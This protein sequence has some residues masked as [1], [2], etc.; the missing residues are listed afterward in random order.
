MKAT[1]ILALLVAATYGVTLDTQQSTCT[2]C[3]FVI[4]Q[5]ESLIQQNATEQEVLGFIEDA[6]NVLPSPY[7]SL[8][9]AEIQA[10]GPQIIQYIINQEPPQTVCTQL[11]LCQSEIREEHKEKVENLNTQSQ[12]TTTTE[13]SNSNCE[14]CNYIVGVVGSYL[15]ASS[16]E[17][18]IQNVLLTKVCVL[19]P[20][21]ECA[22]FVRAY[23]PAVVAYARENVTPQKICAE[24]AS[25]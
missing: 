6:C 18:E 12:S 17:E 14:F 19:D 13:S 15:T 5:V 9:V 25:C 10:E 11:Y 20:S 3:E 4:G 16:T 22:S 1:L 23:L 21:G 2:L 24:I 8:C 7:N